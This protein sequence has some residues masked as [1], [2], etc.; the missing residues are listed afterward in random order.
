MTN[1]LIEHGQSAINRLGS[2]QSG[3]VLTHGDTHNAL[4]FHWKSLVYEARW[5]NDD[6]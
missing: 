3:D 6:C 4:M 1:H 2:R 5:D